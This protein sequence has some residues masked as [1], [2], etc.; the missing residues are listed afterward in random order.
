[1]SVTMPVTSAQTHAAED[2]AHAR[3][4]SPVSVSRSGVARLEMLNDP[5][6][7]EM[8]SQDSIVTRGPRTESVSLRAAAVCLGENTAQVEHILAQEAE[9]YA[10]QLEALSPQLRQRIVAGLG[11]EAVR[12]HPGPPS[13]LGR[14]AA[15]QALARAGVSPSRVRLIVDFSTLPGDR[16]GL[17]SLANRLQHELGCEDAAT[18]WAQGSGCAGLHLALRTACALMLHEPGLDL[19]LLVASDCV[20]SLGRCCLPVSILTDAASA[21]VLSSATPASDPA[22]RI[23]SVHC[24]TLGAYHETICLEGS[25][26]T[27]KVDGHNFESK[28]LPLHFVMSQRVLSRALREA[29]KQLAD[30]STLVYPNTTALDRAS[31]TRALGICSERLSGPGPGQLGHGL[32][33][34]MLINLPPFD[35]LVAK[36][37]SECTALLAVG[38]GFTWGAC[39]VGS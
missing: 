19:A 36:G 4:L 16:P 17:W 20:G 12:V 9:R 5:A 34:D 25:P 14:Q 1:M 26:P 39:I 29:G 3:M 32:A 33:S 38:S 35:Q 7:D 30:I 37:P 31:V 6:A 23:L 11:I 2:R 27:I 13:S 18:L 15:Q 8:C 10:A 24:S 22:P 21:L 28:I